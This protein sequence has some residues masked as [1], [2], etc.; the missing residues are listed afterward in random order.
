V[1][2]PHL[3]TVRLAPNKGINLMLVS[4][5]SSQGAASTGYA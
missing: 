2:R 1:L 5:E 4:V 3:R